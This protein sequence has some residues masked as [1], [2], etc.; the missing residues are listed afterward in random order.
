MS[1]VNTQNAYFQ[2]E[3]VRWNVDDAITHDPNLTTQPLHKQFNTKRKAGRIFIKFGV[4][5]MP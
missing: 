4:D 5:V 2:L 3:V 1:W